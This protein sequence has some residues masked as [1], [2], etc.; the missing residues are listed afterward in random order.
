MIHSH[1]KVDSGK[2][3]AS[4][5]RSVDNQEGKAG[6][7]VAGITSRDVEKDPWKSHGQST[8]PSP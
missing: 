7:S 1:T 4:S 2:A 6:N 3:Y 8:Q 5:L